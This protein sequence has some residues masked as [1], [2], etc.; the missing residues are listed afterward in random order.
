[1][2]EANESNSTDRNA[3]WR[4][5][6]KCRKPSGS[7]ILAI[8]D[9]GD[10]MVYE[11]SEILEVW[12]NHFASLS[13]PK[14]DI[15]YDKVHIDTVNKEV[16]ELNKRDD[17]S[18]FLEHSFTTSEVQRVV[19]RLKSNKAGGFDGICAEHV[20]YGGYMLIITLTMIFNLINKWEHVPLNFKRGI[21]VPLF[22]GKNLCSADT[23]NY[24]GITLLSIFSKVYE[25]IIWDRLEPW[26]KSN[27]VISKFQ[28]ACPKGQSC[29]HTS[30]LLQETVASALESHDRV[31][32]SYFDVSKAFDTVWIN[33]LFSKLHD[34]GIRGKL[35]RLLYRTYTGFQC[36]VRVAGSFSRLVPH[37]M[38]NTSG[39]GPFAGQVSGFY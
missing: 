36:R 23:N 15:S 11:V 34:M 18:V 30:L 13:T 35:W 16:N 28:G 26:W 20:K 29:V 10:K 19:N 1:M 27:E 32:V 25:M 8:K 9:K 5:L 39:W 2:I 7:K 38:R 3:F 17:S 14:D 37:V 33:G 24:R 4:H 21:Q 6:K 22:K 12:R 31:F